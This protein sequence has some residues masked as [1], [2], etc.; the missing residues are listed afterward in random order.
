MDMSTFRSLG[1]DEEAAKKTEAENVSKRR[2]GHLDHLS[3]VST[4]QELGALGLCRLSA[5]PPSSISLK[6]GMQTSRQ[7]PAVFCALAL[8]QVLQGTL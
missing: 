8:P 5:T 7:V 4:V 3:Q 1:D 6:K 2:W